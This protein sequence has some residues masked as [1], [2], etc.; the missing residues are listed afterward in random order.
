MNFIIK[1]NSGM[2]VMTFLHLGMLEFPLER[3]ILERYDQEWECP[4]GIS[5]W[6]NV[7]LKSYPVKV[8]LCDEALSEL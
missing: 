7:G 4:N 8:V 2:L 3:G 5:P 1:D 6:E